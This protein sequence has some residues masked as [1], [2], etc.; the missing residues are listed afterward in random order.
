MYAVTESK[1][2]QHPGERFCDRYPNK[3]DPRGEPDVI[4]FFWNKNMKSIRDCDGLHLLYLLQLSCDLHRQWVI[5]R[6]E[7][8]ASILR[9][10][11]FIDHVDGPQLITNLIKW[12]NEDRNHNV[13]NGK[14]VEEGNG[15]FF[16]S[17]VLEDIGKFHDP[18]IHR[19]DRMRHKITVNVCI[20][21]QVD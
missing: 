20:F 9:T 13:L 2:K 15:M 4:E 11:R 21:K 12:H 18:I 8:F 17:R 19:V 7:Y 1:K 16:C 6:N 10:D 5:E 14:M 3:I